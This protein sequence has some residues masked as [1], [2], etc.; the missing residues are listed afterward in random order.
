MERRSVVEQDRRIRRE[1]RHQP[2][3]HHPAAGGEVEDAVVRVNVAVEL[4]LLQVLDQRAAGAVNDALG[5]AGRSGRVQDVE[6][7]V[8]REPLERHRLRRDIADEVAPRLRAAHGADV[9]PLVHV[10]NDHRVFD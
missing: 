1:H 10:G 8:E 3:P 2:V 4:M 6:R 9:G 5:D 7:V